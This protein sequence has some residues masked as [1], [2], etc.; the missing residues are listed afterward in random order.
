MPFLPGY[1]SFC[2]RAYASFI[3]GEVYLRVVGSAFP[4]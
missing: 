3:V 4:W 1:L 2:R